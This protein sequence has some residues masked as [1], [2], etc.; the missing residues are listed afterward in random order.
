M[1]ITFL[2]VLNNTDKVKTRH[3]KFDD[4]DLYYHLFWNVIELKND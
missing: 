2:F 4:N 3:E 1:T